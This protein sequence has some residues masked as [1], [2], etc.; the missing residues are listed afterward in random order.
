MRIQYPFVDPYRAPIGVG[1][2]SNPMFLD[3]P[4]EQS[5]LIG[6]TGR[7]G[8]GK[9]YFLDVLTQHFS[10]HQDF[11]GVNRLDLDVLV[12]N[13]ENIQAAVEALEK[14]CV[15]IAEGKQFNRPLSISGETQRRVLLI[16]GLQ[17]I[18]TQHPQD[19]NTSILVRGRT[20]NALKLLT[21]LTGPN[22]PVILLTSQQRLPQGL[23]S[24]GFKQWSF[25][26]ES[27]LTNEEDI[28]TTIYHLPSHLPG[29]EP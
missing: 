26:N 28:A 4:A 15:T 18:T 3:I 12:P 8:C 14:L 21:N 16:D 13:I 25:I 10:L 23:L 19:P 2:D 22:A 20:V 24:A 29:S 1:D 6:V 7:P 17:R 5:V 11:F 27:V 9:T